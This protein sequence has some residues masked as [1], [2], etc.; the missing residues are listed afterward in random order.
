MAEPLLIQA[1]YRNGLEKRIGEQLKNA[2]VSFEYEPRRLPIIV[3]ARKSTY[4]PDFVSGNIVIESK[5]YFYDSARD[6]KKLLLVREQHPDLDI[7]LVFSDAKKKISKKSKTT[8][9][10]WATDFGFKW[11]DRGVI[12]DA[13]IKEM[14]GKRKK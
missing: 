9:G 4:L 2:G 6:R 13:W 8:Y 5:G 12:P 1:R 14:K 10:Q 11:A 7:R 3:P